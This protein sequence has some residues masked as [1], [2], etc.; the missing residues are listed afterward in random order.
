MAYGKEMGKGEKEKKVETPFSARIL[1][2]GIRGKNGRKKKRN[3]GANL[4]SARILVN[5]IRKN[6]EKKK[7]WK[8]PYRHGSW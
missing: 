3:N 2:D 5:G 8:T 1:G 4:F 6:G 7:R